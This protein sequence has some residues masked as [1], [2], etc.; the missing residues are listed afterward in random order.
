M[1]NKIAIITAIIVSIC[2]ADDKK[3]PSVAIMNLE[4]Q[5]LDKETVRSITDAVADEV[6]KSRK[7]RVMERSQME[8]ILKEQGFQQ[9][10]ACDG[11]DCAVAIGRLLSIDQM[12]VGSIGKIGES[13]TISLR[14]VNISTGELIN[15]ARTMQRGAIDEIVATSVPKIVIQLF[16][17][18]A[19]NVTPVA[20]APIVPKTPMQVMAIEPKPIKIDT[21]NTNAVKKAA[22]PTI[23]K[24]EVATSKVQSKTAARVVLGATAIGSIIG[25]L[26]IENAYQN[27]VSKYRS[28]GSTATISR[29]PATEKARSP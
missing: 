12:I 17:N 8:Q 7:V 26:S 13:Y 2:T 22:K 23:Q 10:G 4:A 18:N 15:G 19:E 5:T 9:T 29:T 21:V 6:I 20:I 11:T 16:G 25:A 14:L 28:Q 27:D 3:M 1:M 24:N